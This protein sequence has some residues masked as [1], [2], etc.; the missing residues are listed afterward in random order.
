MLNEESNADATTDEPGPEQ[1]TGPP[2]TPPFPSNTR[3]QRSNRG[4]PPPK[5]ADFHMYSA[6]SA[7]KEQLQEINRSI[8]K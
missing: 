5:Y 4:V 3:P 8:G 2:S 7:T 1:T 6:W